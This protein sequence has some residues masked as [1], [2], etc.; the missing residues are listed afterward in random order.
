MA[1]GAGSASEQRSLSISFEARE[2]EV[3][4]HSGGSRVICVRQAGGTVREI[5]VIGRQP[6]TPL[7]F[8]TDHYSCGAAFRPRLLAC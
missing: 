1:S 2:G 7:G 4:S 5:G 3:L 6:L 8:A